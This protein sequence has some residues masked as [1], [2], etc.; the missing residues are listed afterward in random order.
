MPPFSVSILA[1]VPQRSDIPEGLT[2]Y[3]VCVCNY[4]SNLPYKQQ[5]HAITLAV[6]IL[7]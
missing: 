4:L 1:T 7:Y 3:H 5:N 6:A 2:N